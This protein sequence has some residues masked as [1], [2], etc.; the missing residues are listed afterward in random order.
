MAAAEAFVMSERDPRSMN[1]MD[2]DTKLVHARLEEWAKWAKDPG[3]AGYPHQ[4]LTEKAATY[5]KLGIPQEPLHKMEPM[6]PDHVAV[7]DAAICKLGDIDRRVVRSYYLKW[8]PVT[9][10]ARHH[11]MRVLQFQRVLRRARWRIMG[12]LDARS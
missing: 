12:F 1:H 11:H 4:S 10:M 6:M 8:E 9:V 2:P 3:I 7:I 5:G